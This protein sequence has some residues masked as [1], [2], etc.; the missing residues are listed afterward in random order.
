MKTHVEDDGDDGKGDAGAETGAGP[1][2]AEKMT[3]MMM[4]REAV[5]MK[6]MRT[7]DK[8]EFWIRYIG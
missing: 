7:D 4:P 1:G 3:K 8:G 2:Y 6:M 5:A